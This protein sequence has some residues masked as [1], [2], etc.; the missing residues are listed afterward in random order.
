[1]PKRSH[2]RLFSAVMLAALLTASCPLPDVS[3]ATVSR[4]AAASTP[5]GTL[6]IGTYLVQ[7]EALTQSVYTA[8]KGTMADSDQGV[9]YKSEFA[10][11]AWMNIGTANDLNALFKGGKS[12]S[13]PFDTIDDLQIA[14]WIYLQEGKPRLVSFL[15]ST[16][17]RTSIASVTDKLEAKKTAAQTASDSEISQLALDVA[18]LQ[19]QLDFLTAVQNGEESK[20]LAALDRQADPASAASTDLQQAQETQRQNLQAQLDQAKKDLVAALAS[21]DAAQATELQASIQNLT[22][23]LQQLDAQATETSLQAAGEKLTGLLQDLQKATTASQ[24]Q[25]AIKLLPQIVQASAALE[26]VRQGLLQKQLALTTDA[27]AQADLRK[28]SSEATQATL[29]A[30]NGRLRKAQEQA[31]LTGQV[32]LANSLLLLLQENNAKRETLR[33]AD[34]QARLVALQNQVI[35]LKSQY[36]QTPTD[37]LLLA[38]VKTEAQ[39]K[40][41]QQNVPDDA[42]MAQEDVNFLQGLIDTRNAEGD[43]TSA[44]ELQPQLTDAKRRLVHATKTPLFLQKYGVEAKQ[45]ELG[46]P[47]AALS[48]LHKQSITQ[49]EAVELTRYTK[50]ELAVLKQLS[51]QL[52]KQLS[53]PHQILPVDHLISNSIDFKLTAPLVRLNGTTMVPIRTLLEG[54]GAQVQWEDAEQMVRVEYR[55]RTVVAWI[56]NNRYHV[57]GEPKTIDVAPILAVERTYVPLRL[58]VEAFGFDVQWDEPTETIDIKALPAE[59]TR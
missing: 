31:K 45:L 59:V 9:Y 6:L 22:T 16:E 3:A 41:E 24:S 48:D 18:T 42:T 21:G 30:T 50:D 29:L 39:V 58:L 23:Q 1:M 12:V 33:Q 28:Q 2:L 40:A 27:Q 11:G 25:T 56:G 35:T 7:K 13:V 54:F 20:A 10:A 5:N 37:A 36:A 57:N 52:D 55:G 44:A 15:T 26:D 19:A 34:K 38:I 17:V 51:D 14:F 49:I 43:A 32:E 4:P 8:A 47:N 46:K 53:Q